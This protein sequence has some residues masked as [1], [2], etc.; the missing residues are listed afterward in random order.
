[1][2]KMWNIEGTFS[3]VVEADS[4]EEAKNAFDLGFDVDSYDILDVWSEEDDD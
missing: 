4:E 1:M 3:G 2:S